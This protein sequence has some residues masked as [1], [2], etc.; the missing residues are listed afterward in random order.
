MWFDLFLFFASSKAEK[1][2][3]AEESLLLGSFSQ[4]TVMNEKRKAGFDINIYTSKKNL[5]QGLIDIALLNANC[6]QLKYILDRG[7]IKSLQLTT[8]SHYFFLCSLIMVCLSITLQ[9]FLGIFLIINSRTNINL[10]KKGNGVERWNTLILISVFFITCLNILLVIF[11][12][13]LD[14]LNINIRD[15]VLKP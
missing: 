3:E 8:P 11:M 13:G 12:E 6:A 7:P 14:N 1:G 9:V 10:V 15:L 5:A 4:D 2:L